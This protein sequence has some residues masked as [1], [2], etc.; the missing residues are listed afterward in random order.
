M[1]LVLIRHGHDIPA[2]GG[3]SILS[4]QGRSKAQQ[5]AAQLINLGLDQVDAAYSSQLLRAVQTLDEISSVV[6][7]PHKEQTDLLDPTQPS[8]QVDQLVLACSSR[9]LSSVIIV[10]HEPQISNAFLRWCGLPENDP[11]DTV[12][13]PWVFTRGEGVVLLPE[14]TAHRIS[15]SYPIVQFLGRAKPLP[16]STPRRSAGVF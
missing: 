7:I 13:M 2:P 16:S 11:S 3:S 15:V 14:F 4:R 6:T 5:T 1:R 9:G 12:R 8:D 10:A